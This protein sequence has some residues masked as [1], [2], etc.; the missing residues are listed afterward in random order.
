MR[1]LFD[2]LSAVFCISLAI[3]LVGMAVYSAALAYD[4]WLSGFTILAVILVA[5][6]FVCILLL[7][8]LVRDLFRV[9]IEDKP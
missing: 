9:E 5:L 1:H 4:L 3:F 7:V 8:V 6:A 2:A